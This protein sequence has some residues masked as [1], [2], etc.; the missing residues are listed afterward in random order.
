MSVL[1]LFTSTNINFIQDLTRYDSSRIFLLLKIYNCQNFVECVL[2][3]TVGLSVIP[4]S[5]AF[6]AIAELPPQVQFNKTYFNCKVGP[7]LGD[8]GLMPLP[9]LVC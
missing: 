8:R 4:M 2:G 1:K 5:I 7:N 6:A 9:T 3:F